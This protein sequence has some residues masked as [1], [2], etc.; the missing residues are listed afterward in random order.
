MIWN[1][2]YKKDL[3]RIISNDYNFFSVRGNRKSEY[4]DEDLKRLG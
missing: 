3:D 2:H 4:E 1:L